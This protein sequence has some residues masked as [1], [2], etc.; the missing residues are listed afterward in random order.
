MP[1][2]VITLLVN[3]LAIAIYAL[4]GRTTVISRLGTPV[5]VAWFPLVQLLVDGGALAL[6]L[7]L[8]LVQ[9]RVDY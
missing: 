4:L 8:R 7:G 6:L 3:V 1:P 9:Y 5:A 2:L